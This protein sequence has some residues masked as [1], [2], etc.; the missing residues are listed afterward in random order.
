MQDKPDSFPKTQIN[1]APIKSI[2]ETILHRRATQS[3]EPEE[4]PENYLNAILEFGAQAPSGYNLQPWRII[5]V[6]EEEN[7]KKLQKAAFNQRKIGEAPVV[8]IV[9]GLKEGWK[10]TAE[11]VFKKGAE[12]G[13][14]NPE[15]VKEAKEQAMQFLNE[16]PM[17]VW[18]TRHSMIALT[19][20]MLIAEAFGYQTAPM[21]GFEPDAIKKEFGIPEEGEV[22]SLLGIGRIKGEQKPYPGRFPI[23]RLVFQ[24]HYGEHWADQD[25]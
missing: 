18:V 6:R 13:A 1:G 24:E 16:L 2:T 20:M 17:D 19:H 10:E 22:V 3:F 7:R 11:E 12:R 8:L 4:I 9:V 15:K 23:N 21:E 14:G 25:H 5:V